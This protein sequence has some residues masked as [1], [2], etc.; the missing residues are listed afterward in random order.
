MHLFQ[1]SPLCDNTM[2]WF[3]SFSVSKYIDTLANKTLLQADKHDSSAE[4]TT[5]HPL[6]PTA[7]L[8]LWKQTLQQAL[9]TEFFHLCYFF[10]QLETIASF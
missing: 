7:D 2:F 4:I 1:P 8:W 9:K 5:L 6:P 10:K 3:V